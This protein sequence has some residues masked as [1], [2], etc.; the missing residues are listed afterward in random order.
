MAL[1]MRLHEMN[2]V[3]KYTK[4]EMAW[5]TL[6]DASYT[7]GLHKRY[8]YSDMGWLGYVFATM[9]KHGVSEVLSHLDK[10]LPEVAQQIEAVYSASAHPGTPRL[11][12]DVAT[13]LFRDAKLVMS[14]VLR[15]LKKEKIESLP[16]PSYPRSPVSYYGSITESRFISAIFDNDSDNY[17]RVRIWEGG[18]FYSVA[19]DSQPRAIEAVLPLHIAV[20][21]DNGRKYIDV[22][23]RV[24]TYCGTMEAPE[25]YDGYKKTVPLLGNTEL[26]NV[27]PGYVIYCE[28]TEYGLKGETDVRGFVDYVKTQMERRIEKERY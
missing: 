19:D 9:D 2:G 16:Q 20:D 1:K 18:E 11:F 27:A 4:E 12:K 6:L 14:K 7:Y 15:E 13:E 3:K 24:A 23:L 25:G 22:P 28:S 21:T 10:Y 8:D 5:R 17:A 26:Y